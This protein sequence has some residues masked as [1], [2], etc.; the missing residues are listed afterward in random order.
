MVRA[1]PGATIA[2]CNVRGDFH[3]DRQNRR[4]RFRVDD[5]CSLQPSTSQQD[6]RHGQCHLND[7]NHCHRDR[8]RETDCDDRRR[9]PAAR[10]DNI[11]DNI[12]N[13]RI[14]DIRIDYDSLT[15][16]PAMAA[17]YKRIFPVLLLLLCFVRPA[18][19]LD[20]ASAGLLNH[21]WPNLAS[22]RVSDI[23]R[24]IGVVFSPDL[25]VNDNCRFYQSL[26]FACFQVADWEKVLDDVHR[27]NVL[28]PERHI[29][30]LVLET[31][32]T[33]GNGL[34]L[35]GSYDPGAERSYISA[36]ALQQKLEP[37]GIYYVIISACN[38]GRLLRPSIYNQLDPNN[39]DKL[40][41]PATKGIVNASPDF[42]AS[43]SA[44]TI[45]TPQSSHIETTV[46]GKLSELSP[47]SRRAI[48]VSA[49]TLGI[50]PPKEFAVSDM[51]VAMLTRDPQLHL[52]SGT[53]VDEL[54]RDTAPVDRSEQMFK[55]FVRF[56]NRVAA[57]Q[58]PAK[59]AKKS[60]AQKKPVTHRPAKKPSSKAP[61]RH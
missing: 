7:W 14:N 27:Y 22:T 49:Q 10:N 46:V 16:H 13:Q 33:N 47:A 12:L 9:H 35:Q 5:R 37:E 59:T 39:G 50:A 3:E 31:H 52:D 41:L 61:V 29:F 32:G 44:V 57:K 38:S 53:Y 43:R 2:Q 34:K 42:V 58:Y 30:T 17:K 23:G 25:S 54:S 1:L 8:R 55:N 28:Y 20:V 19:A 11:D 4:H 24:G 45:I 18:S 40:F 15:T 21:A 56:V 48:T 36:G 26:G 51:M 6:R 60:V